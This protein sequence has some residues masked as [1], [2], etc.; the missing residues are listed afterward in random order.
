ARHTRGIANA[1]GAALA[2]A[3]DPLL[4]PVEA[5]LVAWRGLPR[6]AAARVVPGSVGKRGPIG[7]RRV[8][9]LGGIAGVLVVI[10]ARD[11]SRTALGAGVDKVPDA[12]PHDG[13]THCAVEVVHLA[14]GN[15]RC[16]AGETQFL[17]GV[18]GLESLAGAAEE[19]RARDAV[20]AGP[21]HHVHH[22]ARSLRFA[23]AARRRERA[24]LRV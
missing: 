16:E 7:V 3:A 2:V 13:A 11:P 9:P 8:Q 21:R 17:G 14:E 18:A 6:D 1:L 22:H 5:D 4:L 24:L 10:D 12:V 15:C 19:H 23:A 20:A